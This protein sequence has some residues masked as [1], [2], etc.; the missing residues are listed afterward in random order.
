MARDARESFLPV[1]FPSRNS[2]ETAA[3]M[4][5]LDR[6]LEIFMGDELELVALSGI[7]NNFSCRLCCPCWVVWVVPWVGLFLV[8]CQAYCRVDCG[9][10]V[11]P[12]QSID[13][14]SG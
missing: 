4:F 11:F 3:I 9:R 7:L 8:V 10:H 14:S 13:L 12:N 2:G 6:M 5:F 1:L